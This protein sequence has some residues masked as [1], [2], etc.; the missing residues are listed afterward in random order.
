MTYSAMVWCQDCGTV[1]WANTHLM[2]DESGVAGLANRMALPCPVCGTARSFDGIA[3]DN[4]LLAAVHEGDPW[5][6]MRSVAESRNLK[7]API[8]NDQWFTRP[9]KV[10]GSVI[11]RGMPAGMFRWEVK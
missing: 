11:R 8:P 3:K 1:V 10:I 7:W 9:D 5:A 2:V 4:R 6:W